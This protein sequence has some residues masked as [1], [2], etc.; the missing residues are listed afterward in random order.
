MVPLL[1]IQGRSS[2]VTDLSTSDLETL[3]RD[4]E[5][6]LYRGRI[7]SDE[8]RFL[9]LEPMS[10]PPTLRSLGRL[11]HEYA[12]RGELDA[13]WAVRPVALVRKQ[14][15]T[16]RLLEA[17]GGVS[18]DCLLGQPLEL[19]QALRLAIGIAAALRCLH[20]RGLIH[21]DLKPAK[22]CSLTPSIASKHAQV[23][24]A[25]SRTRKPRATPS[26]PSSSSLLS[27][28]KGSQR[29]GS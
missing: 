11:E 3:R 25:A 29:K 18:L 16:I 13:S 8:A 28:R 1:S 24:S 20:E 12:L 21:K 9:L 23:P 22:S 4:G 27:Q 26:L 19:I 6:V 2:P 15:R 5:F 7:E 17:P 10:D 14:G